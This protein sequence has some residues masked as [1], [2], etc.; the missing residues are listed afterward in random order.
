MSFV[1]I[2]AF[3]RAAQWRI[4]RGARGAMALSEIF[5]TRARKSLNT[6]EVECFSLKALGNRGSS[7]APPEDKS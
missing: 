7:V 6:T 4:Q 2:G 1:K 5:C 3:L